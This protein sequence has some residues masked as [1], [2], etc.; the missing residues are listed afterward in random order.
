VETQTNPPE[1]WQILVKRGEEEKELLRTLGS[2]S[3]AEAVANSLRGVY[4][5]SAQIVTRGIK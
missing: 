2:R 3:D 4:G 1:E 5:G